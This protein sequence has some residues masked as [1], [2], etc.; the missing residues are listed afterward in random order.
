MTSS[1]LATNLAW[2]RND[3][4]EAL[5]LDTI[6]IAF[7]WAY[8]LMFMWIKVQWLV[9]HLFGA[10]N[11]HPSNSPERMVGRKLG[12]K[13]SC[14]RNTMNCH[15]KTYHGSR[16]EVMRPFGY[17]FG[18][19][20]LCVTV[21]HRKPNM[22]KSESCCNDEAF[23]G[24]IRKRE[25]TSPSRKLQNIRHPFVSKRQQWSTLFIIITLKNKSRRVTVVPGFWRSRHVAVS[26]NLP[27]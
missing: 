21:N 17:P 10:T 13:D 12:G 27:S 11:R 18:G 22:R 9:S 2:I 20:N 16:C 15:I 4:E 24:P 19:K 3:P 26:I 14:L 23:D 5:H 25:D 8:V 1:V 6:V 7:V